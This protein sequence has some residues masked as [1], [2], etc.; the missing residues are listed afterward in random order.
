[1]RVGGEPVSAAEVVA[2]PLASAD[3]RLAPEDAATARVRSGPDGTFSVGGLPVARYRLLVTPPDR[4]TRTVEGVIAEP[5]GQG[6]DVEVGGGPVD[7][8]V[9]A[10]RRRDRGPRPDRAGEGGG[11]SRARRPVGGP[12]PVA[13]P[14]RGRPRGGLGADRAHRRPRPRRPG[15]GRLRGARV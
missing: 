5:E 3:L 7:A 14:Q 4:P 2:V 15:G 9:L 1:R 11:P 8:R 13:L 6:H 12:A 10:A